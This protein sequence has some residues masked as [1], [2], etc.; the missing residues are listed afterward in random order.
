MSALPP[1]R[2]DQLSRS[3]L[4]LSC[5]CERLKRPEGTLAPC[6]THQGRC[7]IGEA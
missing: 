5:S 4:Q 3:A 6:R 1:L 2:A 7:E